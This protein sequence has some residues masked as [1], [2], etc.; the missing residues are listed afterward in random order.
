MFNEYVLYSRLSDHE[1]ILELWG[2]STKHPDSAF[3]FSRFQKASWL[4]DDIQIFQWVLE[5]ASNLTLPPHAKELTEW[6][7]KYCWLW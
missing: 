7:L 5:C 2:A 1:T 3:C 6:A 4:P